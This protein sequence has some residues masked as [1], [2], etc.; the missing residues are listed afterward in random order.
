MEI[1]NHH[2]PSGALSLALAVAASGAAGLDKFLGQK[3]K[4]MVQNFHYASSACVLAASIVLK[5][6]IF[7]YKDLEVT[8]IGNMSTLADL[9]NEFQADYLTRTALNRRYICFITL[10]SLFIYIY[11][12]FRFPNCS[13]YNAGVRYTMTHRVYHKNEHFSY[14]MGR[15]ILAD[16]MLKPFTTIPLYFP[17]TAVDY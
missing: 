4:N 3:Y 16:D 10:L 6:R 17:L 15:R 7:I 1:A 9:Q 11:D 12:A 5:S 2:G 14:L 13:R 8:N